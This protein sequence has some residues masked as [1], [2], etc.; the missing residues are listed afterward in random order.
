MDEERII[1][2]YAEMEWTPNMCR[3]IKESLEKNFDVK[4]I[5]DGAASRNNKPVIQ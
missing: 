5:I 1:R 3:E 4:V 2:A